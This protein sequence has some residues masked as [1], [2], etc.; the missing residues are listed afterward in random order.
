VREVLRDG[1][2]AL[3]WADAGDLIEHVRALEGD[4]SLAARLGAAGRAALL[5]AHTDERREQRFGAAIQAAA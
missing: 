5:E 2:T 1:E 3:L 4:P